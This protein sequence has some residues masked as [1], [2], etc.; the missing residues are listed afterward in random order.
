MF[1]RRRNRD[2]I[3]TN[4]KKQVTVLDWYFNLDNEKSNF[5]FNDDL[6]LQVDNVHSQSRPVEY[7]IQTVMKK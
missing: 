4:H 6:K 7:E 5:S 2:G 3:L 1:N